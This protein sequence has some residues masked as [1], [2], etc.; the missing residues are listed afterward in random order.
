MDGEDKNIQGYNI[1][2]KESKALGL[3]VLAIEGVVLL[4]VGV[5]ILVALNY[6][7]I[8]PLSKIA[9][10]LFGWLPVK[11]S[12]VSSQLRKEDGNKEKV[13]EAGNTKIFNCPV[14]NEFCNSGKPVVFEGNPSLLYDLPLDSFVNTISFYVQQSIPYNSNKLH[15]YSQTFVYNNNCYTAS[16][17]FLED[18]KL[19]SNLKAPFG[20]NQHL[21]NVNKSTFKVGQEKGNVLI[22]LQKRPVD[23]PLKAKE[24]IKSCTLVGKDKKDYGVYLKV[25]NE[26][27][28][29]EVVN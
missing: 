4:I 27:L 23:A 16:Y 5:G 19:E 8:F 25:D 17:L 20:A 13:F 9:P 10:G 6:S 21:A 7:G 2:E 3:K 29:N 24:E 1:E 12:T 22:Q 14:P 18:T 26:Y 28:S 11:Q 15:G